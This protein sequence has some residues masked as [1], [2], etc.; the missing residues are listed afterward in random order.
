MG[1]I[2]RNFTLDDYKKRD[3]SIEM[4]RR[5]LNEYEAIFKEKK[6]MVLNN[7]DGKT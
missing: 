3:K 7:Y 6:E 5:R 2:A 4:V 1:T